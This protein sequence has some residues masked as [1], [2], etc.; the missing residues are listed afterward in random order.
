[1]ETPY[2]VYQI[3][4]WVAQA[5]LCSALGAKTITNLWDLGIRTL[6]DLERVVFATTSNITLRHEV[7]KVIASGRN[8]AERA[9]LGLAD[10]SAASRAT[11]RTV[12][13]LATML[14]S[15]LHIHRLRQI[16]N[17]IAER[18]G[19]ENLALIH[20]KAVHLDNRKC[21]KRGFQ[22]NEPQTTHSNE[23]QPRRQ[24]SPVASII[25]V[26]G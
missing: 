4:D 13:T 19:S 20:L 8:E 5:Q 25:S 7:G 12:I 26:R 15:G 22:P 10:D 11:D 2:G 18:L 14:L 9:R 21:G 24:R 23:L 6:F 3:I 16:V 1:V 17:C